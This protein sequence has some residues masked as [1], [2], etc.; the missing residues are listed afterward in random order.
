MSG[1][2]ILSPALRLMPQRAAAVAG[3]AAW[4]AALPA[5]PLLVIY[6]LYLS[7]L[8]DR[9]SRDTGLAEFTLQQL[10]AKA[11]RAVL[12]LFGA[13]LLF[14]GGFLLR[15]GADRLIVAVYPQ[16][17]PRPF[18][19]SMGLLCLFASLG[20]L[21]SLARFAKIVLPL[22]LAVLLALFAIS[23]KDVQRNNLFPVTILDLPALLRASVPTLDVLGLGMVLPLFLLPQ[24]ERR[25]SLWPVLVSRLILQIFLLLLL[26][27]TVIGKFG[28]EIT[29]QLTLPFFALVRNLVLFQSLERI[30]ALVVSCWIFPDFLL[31]SLCFYTAQYC[32][33]T[34]FDALPQADD[35]PRFSM[36]RMRWVI[37][38]CSL[39]AMAVGL[40][41][42]PDLTRMH[43]LSEHLIPAFNLLFLFCPL[44]IDLGGHLRGRTLRLPAPGF[45][46]RLRARKPGE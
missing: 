24:V 5:F 25:G 27:L 26:S 33:R 14:Y 22:L 29:V 21:R 40:L 39:S 20:N 30:E 36:E 1:L 3:R 15:A 42:A 34:A 38:L 23:L 28:A 7:R 2:L 19:L 4:A 35:C 18:L 32:I 41:L 13:W 10:G 31:V 9:Q 46:R 43:R 45:L 11:G 16:A 17:S 44:L 6:A 8:W 12:L 37:P